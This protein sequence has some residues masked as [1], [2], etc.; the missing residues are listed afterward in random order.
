MHPQQTDTPGPAPDPATRLAVRL[1]R[2]YSGEDRDPSEVRGQDADDTVERHCFSY[3][4]LI[5]PTLTL[6]LDN[7]G[8]CGPCELVP[9]QIGAVWLTY[10]LLR[11]LGITF[12]ALIDGTADADGGDLPPAFFDRRAVHAALAPH[13]C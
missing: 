9:E 4:V 8:C 12:E 7:G 13:P 10:T 5:R 3:S 2:A 1:I 11:A 6:L